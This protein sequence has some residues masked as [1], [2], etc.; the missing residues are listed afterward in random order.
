MLVEKYNNL[1]SYDENLLCNIKKWY[2]KN[3][4]YDEEYKNY[5]EKSYRGTKLF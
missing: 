5:D 4:N 2:H 3:T 1:S